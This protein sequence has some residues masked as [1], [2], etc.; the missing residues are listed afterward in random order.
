[1]KRSVLVNICLEISQNLWVPWNI[2]F[3][4]VLIDWIL[5]LFIFIE[6]FSLIIVLCLITFLSI[7]IGIALFVLILIPFIFIWISLKI[8]SIAILLTAQFNNI[9]RV[10]FKI[11]VSLVDLIARNKLSILIVFIM[12]L[13]LEWVCCCIALVVSIGLRDVLVRVRV[14]LEVV[15][16]LA[17]GHW[18]VIWQFVACVV[19]RNGVVEIPAGSVGW[20]TTF[21]C[22][23][24]QVCC[25][26]S[27]RWRILSSRRRLFLAMRTSTMS[28]K[29]GPII[30][31]WGNMFNLLN[32]LRR[33]ECM[34]WCLAFR[35]LALDLSLSL[36]L[37]LSLSL[38]LNWW[39]PR[40]RNRRLI[41]PL[42]QLLLSLPSKNLIN[43]TRSSLLSLL[44]LLS[45]SLS[46]YL[47]LLLPLLLS[48]L[49]K[50]LLALNLNLSLLN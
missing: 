23:F 41:L 2:V 28:F 21:P 49:R 43:K 35:L 3:S 16:V 40:Q 10:S 32:L 42:L 27:R 12:L 39:L 1:M 4:I 19:V 14:T 7:S 47:P 33:L 8:V 20:F 13:L 31:L 6:T 36:N 50:R 18:L 46:L 11:V 38:P 17:L 15:V 22:N 48:L 24:G 5:Q 45:L 44:S 9:P 30:S 29:P 26:G 25:Q 37:P 34:P